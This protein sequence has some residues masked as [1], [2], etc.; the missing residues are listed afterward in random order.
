MNKK[1]INEQ[2]LINDIQSGFTKKELL[3]KYSCSQGTLLLYIR[4]HLPGFTFKPN[5]SN[6]LTKD[7]LENTFMSISEISNEFNISCASIWAYIKKHNISYQKNKKAMILLENKT[8]LYDQYVTQNK[9][10]LQL[11]KELYTATKTIKKFL[12]IHNIPKKKRYTEK[13]SQKARVITIEE[14]IN[15]YNSGL[16]CQYISG[17]FNCNEEYIRK[18][19]ENNN[20]PRKN[21]YNIS[22]PEKTIQHLLTDLDINYITNTKSIIYPFELDIYIEEKKIAIEINGIYFHSNKFLNKKYHEYKRQL[23][24]NKGIRLIQLFEDDINDKIEIIKRYLIHTLLL[25]NFIPARKCKIIENIDIYTR[26]E[27]MNKYHIQGYAKCN[28]SIG[29]T[30]NN[31][32]VALM[33][34]DKNILTRYATSQRIQGGFSK[35]LKNSHLNHIITFV[36]LSMFTGNMY[37]SSGF[38]FDKY[39]SPDY[40]YVINNRRIHKFNLRKKQF[41][42]KFKFDP[43]LTESELAIL[44]NINKIYDAGKLRLIWQK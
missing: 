19:L 22:T 20:V 32:L 21:G 36:D 41:A 15:L 39:I 43:S 7:F 34:F 18:I 3:E 31:E 6:I 1:Q 35:L 25:T 44:N 9:S 23:C 14:V 27:F 26:R 16:S 33:L 4:K 13:L 37:Y 40:K 17:L 10:L 11:S 2:E 8:W 29:L 38:T 42:K 28:Y 30:Y 5:F 24:E 12:V